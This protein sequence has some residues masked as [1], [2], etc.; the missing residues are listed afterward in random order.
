MKNSVIIFAVVA[1]IVL[2][3]AGFALT[4]DPKTATSDNNSTQTPAPRGTEVITYTNDGF[5]PSTITV[6]AGSTFTVRNNSSRVLQFDS[7]PHPQHTDNPEL[8]IGSISPGKSQTITVQT[9]GSFK[10]HNHLN[11]SHQGTLIV[12]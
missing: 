7:N 8:N 10:Y 2:G 1:L 3:G 12:L 6:K 5:S 11:D 9:T 4:R